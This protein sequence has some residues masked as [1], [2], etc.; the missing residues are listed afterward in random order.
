MLEDALAFPTSLMSGPFA[1]QPFRVKTE[2][3]K[4]KECRNG[5]P[6]AYAEKGMI[7]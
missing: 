7:E 4:H 2:T 3:K 6:V 5:T 1:C